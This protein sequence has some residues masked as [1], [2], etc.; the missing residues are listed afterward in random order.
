M[1]HPGHSQVPGRGQEGCSYVRTH[2]ILTAILSGRA[3][4]YTHFTDEEIMALTK[5]GA[6]ISIHTTITQ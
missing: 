5:W 1:S 3:F 4:S 2:L 6:E